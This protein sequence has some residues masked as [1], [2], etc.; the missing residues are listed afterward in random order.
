MAELPGFIPLCLQGQEIEIA[1][2]YRTIRETAQ[3]AKNDSRDAPS[4]MQVRL[5]AIKFQ[6]TGKYLGIYTNNKDKPA[7]EIAYYMLQRWGKSE[8]FFKESLAWFNLDYHPGYDI[9]ELEEQPLVDNPDIALIRKGIKGLKNDIKDLQ[10]EIDLCHYKLGTRKDK[11]IEKKINRLEQ[12]KAE[13]G[14]ELQRFE[15]KL[16]ELPDKISILELLKGRPM[17]RCDLEKKKLYDLMQCLAFHS[18]ERLVEIFRDCY[19]DQRDI[20]QILG[21]I[22]RRSGL[23]KLIGDTLVVIIDGIDNKKYRKAADKLCHK[24]NEKEMSLVGRLKVKLSFHLNKIRNKKF[25]PI[26]GA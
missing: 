10:K 23:L 18:R 11:R 4:S 6:S 13:K 3:T 8:N 14:A 22:T 24:P 5:V 7:Q 16:N 9:K 21:I 2:T 26:E 25:V 20:K 15:I 1:E 12:E 17:N 19:D